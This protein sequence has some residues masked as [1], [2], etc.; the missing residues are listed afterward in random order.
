[1]T[2]DGL[3]PGVLTALRD[4]YAKDRKMAIFVLT[5]LRNTHARTHPPASRRVPGAAG[6]ASALS[7]RRGETLRGSAR[8]MTQW[9][10]SL[11]DSPQYSAPSA[12]LVTRRCS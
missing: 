6:D 4:L 7:G 10:R 11:N 9:Q 12:G 3:P 2:C 5:Q 8:Q 1:M